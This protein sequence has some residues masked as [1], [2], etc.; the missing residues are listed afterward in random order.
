MLS[1]LAT[2]PVTLQR[3]VASGQE[4]LATQP[5]FLFQT[6]SSLLVMYETGTE[7]KEFAGDY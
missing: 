3:D 1:A 2:D 4:F 5:P 6:H 7:K